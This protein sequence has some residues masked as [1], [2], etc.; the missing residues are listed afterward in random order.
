MN[1]FNQNSTPFKKEIMKPIKLTKSEEIDMA[2][3][4]QFHRYNVGVDI[5]GRTIVKQTITAT[6]YNK[7][8]QRVVYVN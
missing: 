5:I 1:L 2:L 7:D 6:I 8:H 3:F 4:N